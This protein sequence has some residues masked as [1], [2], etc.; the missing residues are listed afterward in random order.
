MW[1]DFTD[2]ELATLAGHYGLEDSLIF[3]DRLRLA[4]R[5]EVE[6]LLT[7]AEHDLAFPVDFYSD[8]VYN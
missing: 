7:E 6:C 3:N 2:F 8:L 4:N 5:K 1:D